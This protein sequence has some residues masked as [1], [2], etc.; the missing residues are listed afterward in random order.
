MVFAFLYGLSMDYEVFILSRM[1]EE[2]DDTGDTDEAVVRG[3]GRTGRLVTSA[4]L[5]LFLA[6]MSLAAGPGHRRQGARDRAGGRHPARRDGH[7]RAARARRSCRCS[8]SGTG[9]CRDWA[10]R[11]LRVEPSHARQACRP[12]RCRRPRR[13]RAPWRAAARA[14]RSA[15]DRRAQR[16]GRRV[17]RGA[18][19][20]PTATSRPASPGAAGRR[21]QSTSAMSASRR[22]A[23]A[24]GTAAE[25]RL[26]QRDDEAIRPATL[27]GEPLE[28]IPALCCLLDLRQ[29]PPRLR[30][31]RVDAE[32]DPAAHISSRVV[33]PGPWTPRSARSTRRCAC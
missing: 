23:R 2:Y 6:F 14:R 11:L 13:S 31:V 21:W 24:V 4:A 30:E 16:V 12:A 29:A 28:L 32:H 3:I 20:P 9:G 18:A 19:R 15:G 17:A 22:I 25:Q 26:L 5:I 10:A 27:V 7:P 1:R 8:A 33:G